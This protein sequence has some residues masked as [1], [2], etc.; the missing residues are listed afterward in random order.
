MSDNWSTWYCFQFAF[1]LY[2]YIAFIENYSNSGNIQRTIMNLVGTQSHQESTQ[3]EVTSCREV[4]IV[5]NNLPTDEAVEERKSEISRKCETI[6]NTSPKRQGAG[7]SK[8]KEENKKMIEKQEK[9]TFQGNN[10]WCFVPSHRPNKRWSQLH[11]KMKWYHGK[12]LYVRTVA[13][14]L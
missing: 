8:I 13:Y 10:I 9:S 7:I 5:P 12:K 6:S 3:S 11:L 4:T 14:Y 1:Q 2:V